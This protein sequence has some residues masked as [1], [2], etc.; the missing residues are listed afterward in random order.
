MSWSF[1]DVGAAAAVTS[2]D[3]TLSLPASVAAGDLLI[4]CIAGRGTAAF[5]AP[6]GWEIIQQLASGNTSSSGGVGD[7]GTGMMAYR[8]AGAGESAPTFTRSGGDAGY[9]RIVCY[10]HP[11][12]IALG[13]SG[14]TQ[15]EAGAFT[16]TLSAGI[17][18]AT[19]NEL[20]VACLC[21]G[22]ND[23]ASGFVAT[24]PSTASS[25]TDTTTA[26]TNAW[27]ERGD[28]STTAG[29]DTSLAVADAVKPTAGNTGPI[30]ATHV[31]A[32]R[33]VLIAAAFRAASAS[34]PTLSAPS[35][36]GRVPSVSLTY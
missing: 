20:I 32:R 19:A 25:A 14:I 8:I 18:T 35:F 11:A 1:I 23:L 3:I 7:A 29:A 12:A 34:A 2:G 4:A 17:D 31:R 24:D 33:H 36:A 21:G 10:R 13:N 27:I 30:G 5:V 22:D 16:I 26:P 6:S 9:G 15:P 28:G